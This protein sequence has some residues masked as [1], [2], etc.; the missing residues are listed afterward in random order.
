VL[1]EQE[2][3]FVEDERYRSGWEDVGEEVGE[4][5]FAGGRGAGYAY[6]EDWRLWL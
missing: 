1:G 4:S 3:S 5:C 2:V 6:E